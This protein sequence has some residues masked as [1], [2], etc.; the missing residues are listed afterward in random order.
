MERSKTITFSNQSYK[1]ESRA[2]S[3]GNCATNTTSLV[4]LR[5]AFIGNMIGYRIQVQVVE[6]PH[7][8]HRHR[9]Y[10]YR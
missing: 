6:L 4:V 2:T 9:H 10:S 1:V 5:P 7:Q 3:K 8:K